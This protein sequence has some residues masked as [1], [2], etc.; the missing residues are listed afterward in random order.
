[1]EDGIT[2]VF[3][4]GEFIELSQA[5]RMNRVLKKSIFYEPIVLGMT[6]ASLNTTS[7]ISEASFQETTRVLAKAAIRGR[8]DWLKGLKENII[9]GDIIPIGTGSKEVICQLNLEK[10]KK[11]FY[12]IMQNP[13]IFN[14]E[15]KIMLPGSAEKPS[16]HNILMIHQ[17]LKKPFFE[18]AIDK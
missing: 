12:S 13:N 16:S 11:G 10:K 1:M 2:N 15:M 8:I 14:Q 3:L 9:L 18:A 17:I 7:F 6:R 5:Q 4:P